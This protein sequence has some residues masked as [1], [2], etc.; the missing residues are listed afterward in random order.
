MAF[1]GL[2]DALQLNEIDVAVAAISRTNE[3]DKFVDFST[4]YFVGEDA[5]LARMDSTIVIEEVEDLSGYLLA[6]EDHLPQ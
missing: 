6:I 1:D 5:I 3:R 4:V 2:F